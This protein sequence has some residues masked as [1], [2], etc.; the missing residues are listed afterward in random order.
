M[1]SFNKYIQ[2]TLPGEESYIWVD[3]R[4]RDSGR[5]FDLLHILPLTLCTPKEFLD[6]KRNGFTTETGKKVMQRIENFSKQN[7]NEWKI[8][9]LIVLDE[10]GGILA[11][12][13]W[14]HTRINAN[15]YIYKGGYRKLFK[16]I[17]AFLGK[18]RKYVVFTGGTGTGKTEL[19]AAL[20]ADGAQTLNFEELAKHNGSVFGNLKLNTQ[21]SQENF[22]LSIATILTTYEL[23]KPIYVEA[24]AANLGQVYIPEELL[25]AIQQGV[26]IRLKASK[27]VR[28]KR[29]IKYYAGINDQK[30]IKG[31]KQLTGKLGEAL[32]DDL[33]QHVETKDYSYVAERLLN[34]FDI[35]PGYTALEALDCDYELN[36]DD[37]SETREHLKALFE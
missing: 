8:N 19:L 17:P 37:L 6:L 2:N 10:D 5:H 35:S 4:P 22:L 30:L 32:A 18:K 36:A 33:I 24:E 14:Q 21:P 9:K 27:S 25:I 20:E 31:I 16:Y 11:K 23:N 7:K 34:Y 12:A 29:L 3:I 26:H 15:T 28:I 1:N 13:F